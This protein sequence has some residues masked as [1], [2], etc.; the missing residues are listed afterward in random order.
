VRRQRAPAR[1]DVVLLLATA[2]LPLLALI[3]ATTITGAYTW[4]YAI[5][6]VLGICLWAAV[7][8]YYLSQG[9][10]LVGVVVTICIVGYCATASQHRIRVRI[11]ETADIIHV[12]SWIEGGARVQLPIVVAQSDLFYKLTYYGSD[13]LRHRLIYLAD[14]DRANRY[15]RHDT[16]DRSML[17]LRRWF[18]LPIEEYGGFLRRH[19]HFLVVTDLD[20]S[21]NWLP[22]ALIADGRKVQVLARR[23]ELVLAIAGTT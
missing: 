23:Q 12:G 5:P 13:S 7:G 6:G 21:W 19:S 1:Q 15:L 20:A 16:V 8:F 3:L 10:T 22:S 4:R 14:T 18:K 11:S 2:A 9:S 17:S